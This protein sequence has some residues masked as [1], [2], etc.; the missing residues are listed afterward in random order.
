MSFIILYLVNVATCIGVIIALFEFMLSRKTNFAAYERDKKQSTID[1]FR[2]NE[3]EFHE[4]NRIIYKRH[5]YNNMTYHQIVK[6]KEFH[7]MI[8][9]YLNKLELICTGV[10]IGV[11]DIY[12]LERLFGDVMV[13]IYYQTF[14][15]IEHLRN[16]RGTQIVYSEFEI[17]AKKMEEIDEKK[18]RLLNDKA[19]LKYKLY[20]D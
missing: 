1:I 4:Y 16:V 5:K 2:D 14:P 8:H 13:R 9:E 6:D 19:N 11:Y 10:N 20:K 7:N 3:K 15:Y 18:D 12:T 17:V